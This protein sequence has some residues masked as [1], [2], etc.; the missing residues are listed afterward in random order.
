MLHAGGMLQ[1]AQHGVRNL[2]P[3]LYSNCIVLYGMLLFSNISSISSR[4]SLL[5][6]R[7][8]EATACASFA[9]IDL[10]ASNDPLLLLL[11][12]LVK[13]ANA[14][15]TKAICMLELLLQHLSCK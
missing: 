7:S 6:E 1:P 13:G 9:H 12:L 14:A 5:A 2:Q 10:S 3:L 15:R 11:L 4:G 8:M